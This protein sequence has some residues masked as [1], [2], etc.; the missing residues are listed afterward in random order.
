MRQIDGYK[1]TNIRIPLREIRIGSSPLS[2]G[3]NKE[4]I[5]LAK[6]GRMYINDSDSFGGSPRAK[7]DSEASA[8]LI[9]LDAICDLIEAGLVENADDEIILL[10]PIFRLIER[11]V[12]RINS[13]GKEGKGLALRRLWYLFSRSAA[14]IGATNVRNLFYSSDRRL[15]SVVDLLNSHGYPASDYLKMG[16]VAIVTSNWLSSGGFRLPLKMGQIQDEGCGELLLDLLARA[17]HGDRLEKVCL[18]EGNA[19][20]S[21]VTQIEVRHGPSPSTI[22]KSPLSQEFAHI[23][24]PLPSGRSTPILPS[25]LTA[26]AFGESSVGVE[27]LPQLAIVDTPSLRIAS[28]MYDRPYTEFASQCTIRMNL[29][30]AVSNYSRI[31][32][33]LIADVESETDAAP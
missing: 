13:L 14:R 33:I 20:I 3:I 10:S 32:V 25:Q 30:S 5:D 23:V 9:Y 2:D 12:W 27:L 11:G 31:N 15:F 7:Y 6:R 22:D 26:V 17:F 16:G 8:A 29:T 28:R 24:L 19:A 1:E 21:A 4:A 18:A